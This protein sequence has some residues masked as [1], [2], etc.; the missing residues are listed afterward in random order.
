MLAHSGGRGGYKPWYLTSHDHVLFF[1]VFSNFPSFFPL[2]YPQ[3]HLSE[4]RGLCSPEVGLPVLYI[5]LLGLIYAGGEFTFKLPFIFA[6]KKKG[7]AT[8][9]PLLSNLHKLSLLLF[10]Q[11]C[12][13][14]FVF[15]SVCPTPP[16]AT[17]FCGVLCVS[18][19]VSKKIKRC[20]TTL[21]VVA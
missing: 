17:Y 3:S 2:V 13:N 12:N 9:Q 21:H 4:G 20:S 16:S 11:S 10:G 1:F 18:Y 8:L 19:D 5:H 14:Y 15:C 7:R 6:T